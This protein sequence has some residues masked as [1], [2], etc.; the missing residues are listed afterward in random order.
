MKWWGISDSDCVWH[1]FEISDLIWS[2]DV[3]RCVKEYGWLSFHLGGWGG[4]VCLC[5]TGGVFLKSYPVLQRWN[6][7]LQMRLKT[8]FNLET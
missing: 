7:D 4:S 1:I 3:Y 6:V 2:G 5:V 8:Q